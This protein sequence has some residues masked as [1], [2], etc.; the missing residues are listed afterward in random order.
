VAKQRVSF[1]A[2]GKKVA[3]KADPAKSGKGRKKAA[4]GA[5]RVRKSFV[6]NGKKVSFMAW[7]TR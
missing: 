4:E 7:E 5:R 6:A 1:T 3:F 2:N